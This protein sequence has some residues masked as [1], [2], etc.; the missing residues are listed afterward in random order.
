MVSGEHRGKEDRVSVIE[1]VRWWWRRDVVKR[2]QARDDA[3]RGKRDHRV[4]GADRHIP[5]MLLG[6]VR[7]SGRCASARQGRQARRIAVKSGNDP[8][9][10]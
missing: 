8:A 10:R 6:E 1:E 5:T 7:V 2:T 4:R 3:T 9:V